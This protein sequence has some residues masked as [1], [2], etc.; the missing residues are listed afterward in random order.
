MTIRIN[1]Y[2]DLFDIKNSD[3]TLT[4]NDSL[5]TSIADTYKTNPFQGFN[6]FEQSSDYSS[7]NTTRDTIQ[8]TGK[9]KAPQA[10]NSLSITDEGDIYCYPPP[11]LVQQWDKVIFRNFDYTIQ[12]KSDSTY[13]SLLDDNY[14]WHTERDAEIYWYA[15]GSTSEERAANWAKYITKPPD[16]HGG[17]IIGGATN[18]VDP[19]PD[20]SFYQIFPKIKT[21][22]KDYQQVPLFLKFDNYQSRTKVIFSGCDKT[23]NPDIEFKFG[24]PHSA[25]EP[26]KL[27]LS[28]SASNPLKGFNAN[29]TK[30]EIEKLLVKCYWCVEWIGQ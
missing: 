20:P 19:Q 30:D 5:P 1:E 26:I 13:K 8:I 25:M 27:N 28:L 29:L 7:V 24:Y 18:L 10:V 11:V 9:N 21:I 12:P 16:W 3:N 17:Y 23:R 14:L 2:Y 15:D 6:N 4:N 22:I